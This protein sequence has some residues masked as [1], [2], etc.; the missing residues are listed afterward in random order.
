MSLLGM[1]KNKLSYALILIFWGLIGTAYA[2]RTQ[3]PAKI[4]SDDTDLDNSSLSISSKDNKQSIWTWLKGEEP[5]SHLY[6]GMLT[7]HFNSKSRHE[8]RWQ[9]QLIAGNYKS[10][11][12]GTFLNS[13]SDRTYVAG[14]QRNVF[15]RGDNIKGYEIGYRAG[16]IYGYEERFGHIA[17]TLPVLPLIQPYIAFQYRRVGVEFSY[18]GVVLTAEFFIRL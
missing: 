10:F 2:S 17:K 1:I 18:I 7:W 14:I 9:N 11:F 13:F 8:D 15:K 12:A 3:S 5:E 6:L 16:G 4:T